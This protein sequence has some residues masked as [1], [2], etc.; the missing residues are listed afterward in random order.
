VIGLPYLV[1]MKM[2]SSRSI[3]LGDLGRLLGL[4]S[5]PDLDRVR[6]AVRLDGLRRGR[7]GF[8]QGVHRS[9]VFDVMVQRIV[10]AGT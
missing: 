3:D 6:Q 4:A 10:S 5:E 8:G 1:L 7:G 2:E 9:S